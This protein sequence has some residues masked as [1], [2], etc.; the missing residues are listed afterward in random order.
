M[1]RR[2]RKE[3]KLN[4]IWGFQTLRR[5]H[6]TAPN[7]LADTLFEHR[8]FHSRANWFKLVYDPAAMFGLFTLLCLSL[9]AVL[10]PFFT[11]YDPNRINLAAIC[12]PPSSVHPLGTDL[13]GRDL[14]SRCLFGA[15]VSLVVGLGSAT[16]AA[17]LGLTLGLLAALK[18]GLVDAAIT[19]M[20]DAAL[21]MPALFLV[22]AIQSVFGSSVANV[23]VIVSLAGWMLVARIVRALIL[24]LKEREFILAARALGCS[25]SRIVFRH[26]IPN[27]AGQVGILFALG[28]ADALLM[29]SALSFL[30]IGVPA[31]VPSWGNMLSDAQTAILSG[32]WWIPAAP[33]ALILLA[34]LAINLLGDS[35]QETFS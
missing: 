18:G 5:D 22:I 1:A 4:G 26:L 23:I 2:A 31:S 16:I 34:T 11:G 13:L 14:L 7:K 6:L 17:G 29:E 12:L 9:A 27:I 3:R 30:G 33:G 24:S 25:N 20:V 28:V 32:A 15:R 19:R 35:L 10:A 8:L 21:A